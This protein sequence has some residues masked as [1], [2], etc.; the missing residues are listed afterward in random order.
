M[1][2]RILPLLLVTGLLSAAGWPDMRG[3]QP[4]VLD[5]GSRAVYTDPSRLRVNLGEDHHTAY[6]ITVV[7]RSGSRMECVFCLSRDG[8]SFA[9]HSVREFD[10]RGH[11]TRMDSLLPIQWQRIIPG[12]FGDQLRGNL[13]HLF[14]AAPPR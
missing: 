13:I 6:A 7:D 4:L 5:Q 3:G 12:S 9:M 1:P 10:A 11:L 14:Q 2:I 8:R